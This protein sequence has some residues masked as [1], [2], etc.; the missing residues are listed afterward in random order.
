MSTLG[1]ETEDPGGSLRPLLI[2]K[3]VKVLELCRI[4]LVMLFPKEDTKL[5]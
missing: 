1:E 3:Q 2:E 4:V 5:F